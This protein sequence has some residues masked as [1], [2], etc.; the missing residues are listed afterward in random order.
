MHDMLGVPAA[1]QD[2]ISRLVHEAVRFGSAS[3]FDDCLERAAEVRDYAHGLAEARRSRPADD[4]MTT[5]VGP[6]PDGSMLSD[7]DVVVTFW[8]VLTAGSDTMALAAAH[9]M[10]AL[11]VA[12]DQRRAL[13][14]DYQS[15]ADDAVEEIL[16]WSTPVISMRRVAARDTE[17]AG[18]PIAAG[19][20]VLVV[21]ASANRDELVFQNP[22][23]FDI[24]RRPNPQMAFGPGGP[25]VCL[26]AHLARLELKAFFGELFRQLPDV[27]V[28]GELMYVADPFIDDVAALPCRFTPGSRTSTAGA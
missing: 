27:E 16:R 2:A 28:T 25:H 19:E 17:L 21:Y 4:L 18:Q 10:A 20:N 3:S 7:E 9:G 26:G 24:E 13:Q 23:R 1:D 14:Q 5:I 8:M 11:A 6:G 15:L 12:P 22:D